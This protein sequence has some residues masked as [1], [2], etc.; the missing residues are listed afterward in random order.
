[1][2][3][4]CCIN[5]ALQESNPTTPDPLSHSLLRRALSTA[6]ENSCFL[7]KEIL[8][9]YI[10]VVLSVPAHD[11]HLLFFCFISSFLILLTISA[12]KFY[13]LSR[14]YQLFQQHGKIGLNKTKRHTH[15]PSVHMLPMIEMIEKD[16][17]AQDPQPK[18]S[19]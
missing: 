9:I 18:A 14:L 16:F 15:I 13:I 3:E 8:G 17:Q 11:C 5:S 4:R 7:P 19:L 6:P 1:M 12:Q 2:T 10:L